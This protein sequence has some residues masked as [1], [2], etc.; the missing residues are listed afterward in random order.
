[1]NCNEYLEI[2]MRLGNHHQTL[3]R[4]V[5]SVASI[6]TTK[7]GGRWLFLGSCLD[8]ALSNTCSQNM[9]W[10]QHML[11]C[12]VMWYAAY[13]GLPGMRAHMLTTEVTHLLSFS[14]LEFS[15]WSIDFCVSYTVFPNLHYLCIC[16]PNL[17]CLDVCIEGWDILQVPWNVGSFANCVKCSYR[18]I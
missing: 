2:M 12:P 3:N 13:L 4:A 7:D 5:G 17:N 6:P 16:L 14:Y 11:P 15:P 8:L 9:F 10:L 18:P 1:M